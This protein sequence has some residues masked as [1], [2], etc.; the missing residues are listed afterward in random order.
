FGRSFARAPG[1]PEYLAGVVVGSN[2][3]AVW[4]RA[5]ATA[6]PTALPPGTRYLGVSI[7]G[8]RSFHWSADALPPSFGAAFIDQPTFFSAGRGWAWAW[9]SVG[10][11]APVPIFTTDFGQAWNR[12]TLPADIDP[13]N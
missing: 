2:A 6:T 13:S 10:S 4:A 9:P 7:D 8:G 3:E 5:S 1:W 11:A 12:V